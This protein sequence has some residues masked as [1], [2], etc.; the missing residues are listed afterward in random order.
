MGLT[1]GGI[2]QRRQDDAWVDIAT[3]ADFTQY[4]IDVWLGHE[5]PDRGL[6]PGF[7]VLHEVFHPTA[8]ASFLP[9]GERASR[10]SQMGVYLGDHMNS[11]LTA[12]ELLEGTRDLAAHWRADPDH[13]I[14][15]FLDQVRGLVAQHGQVRLV[16]GITY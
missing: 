11:W 3:D 2:F 16:F 9:P 8:D 14:D 12:E 6:P 10:R 13:C 15:E 5:T 7:E 1:V 4:P